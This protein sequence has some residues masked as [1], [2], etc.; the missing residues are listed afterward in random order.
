VSIRDAVQAL[1]DEHGDGWTV[2]QHVVVMGLER[3][4]DGRIEATAWVW[5]PPSQPDWM[6]AGLLDAGIALHD[7]ADEDD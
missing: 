1:L 2:T 4:F 7:A 5:A 6:T 3:V